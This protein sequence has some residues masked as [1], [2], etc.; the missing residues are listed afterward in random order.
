ML[1][2]LY[3]AASGMIAEQTIQD[4]LA[5]NIANAGTIGYKQDTPTFRAV[6]GMTLSRLTGSSDR[7]SRIGELGMGVTA[8]K[9][10]TDW[11]S[12]PL[13]NTG[14]AL[15][16]SL[17]P[18]QYFAVS[19]PNGERY[20]RAGSFQLDGTGN[21]LT[22]TGLT[23]LNNNGRPAAAP[24]GRNVALDGVGN[25]TSDGQ[26]VTRLRI[27]QADPNSLKHDGD[28]LFAIADPTGV[29]P[30]ANPQLHTRTVELSNSNS[31]KDLVGLINV[32]RSFDM[33]QRAILTQD[34]MLRHT[35]TEVG[36][37]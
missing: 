35:T 14:S 33:A 26:P 16:A 29:R 2:G 10:V 22:S 37:L 1:R 36:K 34:E 30:A 31:V 19:T 9:V 23:V 11:Q 25:L 8:D 7:G 20:T 4:T 27:V 5:Q 18:N 32:S 12:G 15:D 21:L 28:G 6:Q 24:N 13:Q 17:G 3:A